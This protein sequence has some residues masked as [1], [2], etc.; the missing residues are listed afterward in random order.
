VSL[1]AASPVSLQAVKSWQV[2]SDEWENYR[3]LK[4]IKKL[5]YRLTIILPLS[6]LVIRQQISA[7]IAQTTYNDASN[8]PEWFYLER[9]YSIYVIQTVCTKRKKLRFRRDV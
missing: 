2:D 1:K 7:V 6:L 4:D 5:L 3:K 9:V 8:N